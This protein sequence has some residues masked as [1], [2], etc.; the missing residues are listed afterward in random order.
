VIFGVAPAWQAGQLDVAQVLRQGGRGSVGSR[1]KARMRRVLVAAQFALSLVLMIAASLLLR[2][3]SDLLN[4]R[5]GFDPAGVMSVKTRLPY[6]NNPQADRYGTVAQQA[7][8]FREILRRS[9]TLPG[10]QE[11]AMGNSTAIPLDHDQ[12]DQNRWSLVIE[13]RA[14]VANQVPLVNQSIIVRDGLRLAVTGTIAGLAGAFAA[15]RLMAGLLYGVKP[16]DALIFAGVALLL[17]GVALVACY[18]PAQRA[19]RDGPLVALSHE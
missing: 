12:Q 16:T 9:R 6:P 7:R 18:I 17:I 2:S 19:V 11:A 10:V 3:F 5:L 15:A 8:L 1:D 13:G 14:T 4:V